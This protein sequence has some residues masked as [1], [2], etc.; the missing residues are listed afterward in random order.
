MSVQDIPPELDELSA[1]PEDLTVRRLVRA[2]DYAEGFWLGLAKSNTPAQRR[3]LAAL[4]R[5]LLEPLKIRVLEIELTEPV[6]DL[7]PI[8]RERLAQESAAN[9]QDDKAPEART[10]TRPK[11]AFFVHG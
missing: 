3:R 8:L 7:L 6:T 2:I 5:D 9:D 11:L 4:S 10:T 1:E